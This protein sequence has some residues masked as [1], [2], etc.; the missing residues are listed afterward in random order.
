MAV[1]VLR[2]DPVA[3]CLPG[4]EIL[5]IK[6]SLARAINYVRVPRMRN[7]RPCLATRALPPQLDRVVHALRR[8]RQARR[9]QRRVVLLGAVDAVWELIVNRDLINLSRRLVVDG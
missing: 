6:L 9:N 4:L 8:R 3:R 1:T 2:V 5:A 7:D